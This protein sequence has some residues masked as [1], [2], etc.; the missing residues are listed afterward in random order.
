VSNDAIPQDGGPNGFVGDGGGPPLVDC[1]TACTAPQ[2]T[3]L[4]AYPQVGT[5]LSDGGVDL[6]GYVFVGWSTGDAGAIIS[7]YTS[8]TV[9]PGTGSPLT[10]TFALG[11]SGLDADVPLT[12]DGG[13]SATTPFPEAGPSS[14]DSGS[15]DSGSDDSGDT[16]V[17]L[18]S[19][20][21]G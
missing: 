6:P 11:S 3:V 5:F 14:D 10:A 13:G 4:Y 20:G 17:A 7:T 15:E 8:L 16:G 19:G 21:G 12:E 9:G 2:G 1:P 18:D